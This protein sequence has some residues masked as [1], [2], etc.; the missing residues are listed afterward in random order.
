[1]RLS[2]SGGRFPRHTLSLYS[3]NLSHL[4]VA[5]VNITCEVE[6]RM[7]GDAKSNGKKSNSCNQAT[8]FCMHCASTRIC[9]G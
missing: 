6:E 9:I 5:I 3:T 1:M 7:M 8:R 2:S 4:L